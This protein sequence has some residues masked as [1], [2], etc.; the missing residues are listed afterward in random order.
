MLAVIVVAAGRGRRMGQKKQYHLLGG[1]PV[2][3]RA[4]RPFCAFSPCREQVVV[5]PAGDE[6]FVQGLLAARGLGD[7]VRVVA[8][9]EERTDSVRAG[10][11]ALSSLAEWVFV[12]DAAR[13]FAGVPLLERL[14]ARRGQADGIIPVVPVTDTIKEVEGERVHATVPRERLRAVQTPQL[15]Q[16]AGLR[17][18]HEEAR[19]EGLAATDDAALLERLGMPVLTVEGEEGNRKLT[20]PADLSWAEWQLQGESAD[21]ERIG[22][23]VDSHRLVEGRPL[24]LA[25]VPV[26]FDRGLIGHSDADVLLHSLMDALLSAAGLGDIGQQ[27][28]PGDPA[29]RGADSGGL[30]EQVVALL[31]E[32]GWSVAEANLTLVAEAP[33]IAGFLPRMRERVARL[34]GIAPERVAIKGTTADRLGA[35]G[36]GEGM[37][38]FALVRIRRRRG[39]W[40]G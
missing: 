3:V 4:L 12:H 25:G 10:L 14:W 40:S 2:L 29:Y 5:V 28:P 30:L 39:G 22:F 11:E 23:G 13:P 9:G 20:T 15:F 17:R 34:L 31:G 6:Q 37:Q 18:A 26:P 24:V 21:E 32:A 27:F 8:G 1:E 19:A 7:G 16:T 36:R 38:A 35:L 33:R